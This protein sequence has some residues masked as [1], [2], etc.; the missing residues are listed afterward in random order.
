M[1]GVEPT[2]RKSSKSGNSGNCVEVADSTKA[3]MVRDTTDRG[4][5]VLTVPAAAWERF[6]SSVK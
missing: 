6:T 1:D 4:G 5:A 2:W 3:V